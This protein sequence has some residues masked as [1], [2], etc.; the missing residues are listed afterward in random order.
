MI[1]E[2]ILQSYCPFPLF[3]L[4]ITR[5]FVKIMEK[6]KGRRNLILLVSLHKPTGQ[7]EKF[8]SHFFLKVAKVFCCACLSISLASWFI[9]VTSFRN[10][11]SNVSIKKAFFHL[12][13]KILLNYCQFSL[14]L[15]KRL[16]CK[17]E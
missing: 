7:R 8:K 3:P 11:I 10:N 16:L 6:T 14:F 4:R 13:K 1:I 12:K 17:I 2:K 9:V 5:K 15:N